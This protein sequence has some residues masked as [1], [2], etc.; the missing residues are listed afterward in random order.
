[1]QLLIVMDI[2]IIYVSHT[3]II[4]KTACTIFFSFSEHNRTPSGK[5]AVN[6]VQVVTEESH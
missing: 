6:G 5:K 3:A 1:M 2:H 4:F